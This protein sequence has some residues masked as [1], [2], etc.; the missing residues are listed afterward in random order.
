MWRQL[1][2][3]FIA[4]TFFSSVAA[5]QQPCTTDA[6]RVVSELYRHILERAPDPGAQHWQQQIASGGMTVRELVR[7]IAVSQ[8]HMQRFGQTENGEGTAYERAVARL[9]RHVLSRQPD[10]Q[11]Q[12]NYAMQAQQ[13]GLNSVAEALVNSPEYTNAFGDW[14]VPGS[15]GMTFCA[16]ANRSSS[17]TTAQPQTAA[18]DEPRFR[19]MDRNNNGVITRDEWRGSNQSFRVHDWNGDGVLSNDEVRNG[20]FRQGRTAEDEDFDRAEQFDYLDTNRNGQIEPREWHMSL[21]AFNRLDR[22]G[23]G[24]LSR[25]ETDREFT[26]AGSRGVATTGNFIVVDPTVRWTD[27]GIDVREGDTLRF[28]VDGR[29]QLSDNR[30]D[31]ADAAGSVTNRRAEQAPVNSAPAGGLIARIGNSTPVYVGDRRALRAPR[32]GR[33]Y[34]GVNDDFLADNEGEYRVSV[35]VR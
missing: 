18:V 21:Q 19:S 22:N 17:N 16:P 1:T 11:G 34:L 33:L 28:D 15:G 13:R 29:I 31:V 8:E 35:D 27:S 26:G 2:S 10:P 25:S 5:A 3:T 4:L 6:S 24:V 20:A 7:A 23:D 12:H 32:S 30:S 14:G 9:Y